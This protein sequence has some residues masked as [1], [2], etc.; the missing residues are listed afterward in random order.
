METLLKLRLYF[1]E[2]KLQSYTLK[3][4]PCQYYQES[5]EWRAKTLNAPSKEYLCKTII[6][7][8]T[9]YDEKYKSEFYSKYICV[10]L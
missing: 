9:A 3:I 10:T 4:V 7:Q 1:E 8:N 5:L 6:M 2:H